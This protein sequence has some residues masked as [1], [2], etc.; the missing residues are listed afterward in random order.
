[1]ADL[2]EAVT[3]GG[4]EKVDV[5]FAAQR[6]VRGEPAERDDGATCRASRHHGVEDVRRTPGTA[7]GDEQITAA[8]MEVD[9][10]GKDAII[11]EIVAETGEHGR[12]IQ[13]QR[14]NFSV[15]G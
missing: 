3:I 15:F 14:A 8:R 4:N 13:R 6:I 11:A 7:D 9:L 12:I 2:D 1:M 10:L 5:A